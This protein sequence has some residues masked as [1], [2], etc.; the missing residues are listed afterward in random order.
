MTHRITEVLLPSLAEGAAIEG[1]HGNGYQ[2]R[3][4]AN[5]IANSMKAAGLQPTEVD[6]EDWGWYFEVDI[7]SA[8]VL[9]GASGD[10]GHQASS[11]P[12]VVQ[13][14]VNLGWLPRTRR[15][16]MSAGDEAIKH[17]EI[18]LKAAEPGLAKIDWVERG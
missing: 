8:T 13:V 12:Y 5:A 16:R 9:I 4:V 10:P 15:L 18:A 6:Q 14:Q 1:L 2:G 7:G 11:D 3:S 17:V